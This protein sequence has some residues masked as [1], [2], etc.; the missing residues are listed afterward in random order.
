MSQGA[1]SLLHPQVPKEGALPSAKG[2]WLGTGGWPL[3]L[4]PLP[5]AGPVGCPCTHHCMALANCCRQA[6]ES[7]T[8]SAVHPAQSQQ[9]AHS[10]GWGQAGAVGGFL[11]CPGC[12]PR[13]ARAL[14]AWRQ[15]TAQPGPKGVRK[16]AP[17][18]THPKMA[19]LMSLSVK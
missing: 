15:G 5:Q 13:P 11:G 7:L 14:A 16:R 18:Y 4:S 10:P 2:R 1:G 17:C 3:S 6:A 12:L 19:A 9:R 8:R